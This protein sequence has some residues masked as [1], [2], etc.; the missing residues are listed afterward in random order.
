MKTPWFAAPSPKK[1]TETRPSPCKLRTEGG[2]GG[3]GEAAAHDA[4]RAENSFGNVGDVHGAAHAVTDAVLFAPNLRHHR[5]GVATLGEEVTMA[6]MSAGDPVVVTQMVADADGDRLLADIE[7]H[8]ARQ[9]A[10][11]EVRAQ[12]L[13]HA[14]DEQHP[15]IH[16]PQLLIARNEIPL[17]V[18]HTSAPFR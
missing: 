9:L 2:A 18:S 4:V 3:D 10:V 17:L 15:L 11:R 13:L 1:A 14:P 12:A 6:A 5:L 16:R 8:R 7:M